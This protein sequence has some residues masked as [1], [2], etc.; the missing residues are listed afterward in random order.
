MPW[1][2]DTGI[3]SFTPL[4]RTAFFGADEVGYYAAWMTEG[5]NTYNRTAI[6]SPPSWNSYRSMAMVS[7]GVPIWSKKGEYLG[8]LN[9]DL[10]MEYAKQQFLNV[11]A[12][13]PVT[14]LSIMTQESGAVV[15]TPDST[16]TTLWGGCENDL[17]NVFSLSPDLIWISKLS[18]APSEYVDTVINGQDYIVFHQTIRL[19]WKLW[20]FCLRADAFPTKKSNLPKVISISVIVPMFVLCSVFTVAFILQH[21]NM[22][23]KVHMLE[24]TIGTVTSNELIGTPA[25]E[26]IKTLIEVQIS[27]RMSSI[28]REELGKV[29]ALITANKLFK[30][31]PGFRKKLQDMNVEKEAGDFLFSVLADEYRGGKSVAPQKISEPGRGIVEH[32]S[33]P[34]G[35]ISS[36]FTPESTVTDFQDWDL[37][38]RHVNPPENVYHLELMGIAVMQLQGLI[39][40]F[41]LDRT[42]VQGFLRLVEGGYNSN[43]F[44][45]HYHA[46]DTAHAMHLLLRDCNVKFTALER[47]AAVISALIHDLR[48]PGVNNAYLQATLDPLFVRYN[49]LSVLESLHCAEGVTMLLQGDSNFLQ[50]K[51]SNDEILE[52]HHIMVSLVLATDMT[53]HLS[54][55]SQFATS[56]TTSSFNPDSKADRLLA[57]QILIKTADVSNPAHPWDMAESWAKKVMEEFA[58]QGDNEKLH[59]L[60]VS[61]FMER[62]TQNTGSCQSAFIKFVVWPLARQVENICPTIGPLM[63][64]NLTHN[65]RLWSQSQ[66]CTPPLGSPSPALSNSKL[67]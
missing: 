53:K 55:L 11:T 4:N 25:E 66:S 65:L 23:N 33:D 51:L 14:V 58:L 59:G 12:D 46:A 47:L 34:I 26:A 61:A 37:D 28:L 15:A 13:S 30:V 45:N 16:I 63:V 32:L 48:H 19:G 39:T 18:L 35:I 21:L 27:A 17:C 36:S 50:G 10:A 29:I 31:E 42:I 1:S 62:S 3:Y 41:D 5:M 8:S 52:L 54:L 6:W 60:P 44:H 2:L 64:T 7:C 56:F 9:V 57:L 67:V 20:F 24:A 40:H 38:V 22:Q 49:G 43:P